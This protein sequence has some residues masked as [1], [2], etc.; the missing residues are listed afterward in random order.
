[1]PHNSLPFRGSAAALVTPFTDGGAVDFAALGRLIE[2]QISSGTDALVILGTTGESSALTHAERL[3]CIGFAVKAARGRV[4]VIAGV[5]SNDTAYSVK[6]TREA[7]R[8]GADA[9]LAVT[10]YYN[11]TSPAGLTAH[12]TAIAQASS[13]PVILYNV[14]SRTG[15][16]I[17]LS[18]YRELAKLENI[19]AVK[20]AS[21]SI[22]AVTD[23]CAEFGDELAVYSGNDDMIVPVL[24]VGGAGVISVLANIMPR[25]VS[26]I[27]RHFERGDIEYAR[28]EQLRLNSLIHA[29]F[30]EVNPIPIKCACAMMG[31][32]RETLRLPLV[33]LGE[34]KR[35]ALER[36][37]ERLG[38]R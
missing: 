11:K 10:P 38:N 35:R 28:R 32:C 17:P 19:A 29:L 37:I 23:I 20:E 12:F 22:S 16:S 3:D 4:P 15:M 13:V 1:M 33:K 34:E 14:P 25:E 27:C 5:G 26:E 36:E 31:L 24:S 7:C 18:V 30:C 9:L 6:L 21:G 8:M 2:F